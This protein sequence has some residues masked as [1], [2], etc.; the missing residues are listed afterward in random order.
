MTE[1][2]QSFEG[3]ADRTDT[4]VVSHERAGDYG[5]RG[6]ELLASTSPTCLAVCYRGTWQ[7]AQTMNVGYF[8]L[9]KPHLL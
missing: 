4:F 9:D 3:R 6:I 2:S 5:V 8:E 1:I 7:T